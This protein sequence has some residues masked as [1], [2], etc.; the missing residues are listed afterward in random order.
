MQ[1]PKVDT[2]ERYR[3]LYLFDFGDWTAIGYT[4][5]E[6]AAL[7]ESEQYRNGK[8]YRIVRASPAGEFELKGVAAERFQLETALMFNRERLGDA[9]A[10][11]AKLVE[12]GAAGA[13]CRGF[14]HLTDRGTQTDV[15]RYVTALIYPAEYD[16]EVASWLL[17]E[18]FEG[19]D[20]VEGGVSAVTDYYREHHTI[21]ERA[22]LWSRSA[23]QSRSRDELLGSV[24][25]AVQR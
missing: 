2:P 21:L 23:I 10:D 18:G 24:R 7:L 16:D 6:I 13:P 9:R 3:G 11:F 4:A 1:I 14:V 15:A 22:Q 5:E 25:R 12:M 8:V 17:A 20:F 19:G